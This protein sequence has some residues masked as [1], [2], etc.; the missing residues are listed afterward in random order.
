[1][2]ETYSMFDPTKGENGAYRE[3]SREIA[4]KFIASAKEVEKQ[5]A[6]DEAEEIANADKEIARLQALKAKKGENENE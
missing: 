3:I 5:I 4:E 2:R 1:M 6:E